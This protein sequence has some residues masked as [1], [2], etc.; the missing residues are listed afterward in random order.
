MQPNVLI[1]DDHSMIRKGIKLILQTDL[2]VADV[3][4]ATSCVELMS[5]L[6]KKD[7]TH[8][9]LDIILSDGTSLEVIPNIKKIYPDLHI[10]IFSMLSRAV[11]GEALKQYQIHHYLEKTSTEAETI[12]FLSNFIQN[13]HILPS[14][15]NIPDSPANP[16]VTLS[17]RELEVL[18]YLL[19]GHG[20]KEISSVLNLRMNTVSTL[21]T[22]IFEKTET[23]N[24]KDLM[25]LATL[26]NV[27]Y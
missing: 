9:I 19:K 12:T 7:Y 14:S 11:Y 23:R 2:G 26:Y 16:F 24:L 17:A 20:T 8:L 25:Q 10:M 13:D 22:R 21:K 18:H 4:E 6:L 1:A 3:S 15:K 27:N 5:E